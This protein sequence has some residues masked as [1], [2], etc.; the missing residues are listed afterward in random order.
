MFQ[1]YEVSTKPENGPKRLKKLLDSLKTA[2]FDGFLVPRSDAH[3]G[4]DVAEKDERLA[5]LTGFTGSAGMCVVTQSKTAIFV[6]SRY[7]LQAAT[8]VDTAHFAIKNIPADKPSDFITE[9]LNKGQTLAIDPWLHTKGEIEKIEEALTDAGINIAPTL[10][11]VDEIWENQPAPPANPITPHPIEFSGKSQ[12]D[13]RSEIAA[14]LRRNEVK[15]AILTLPDSIAWLLNIRGSDIKRT[16]VPLAFAALHDD[17]SV[18]LITD[19]AKLTQEVRDHLG[20]EITALEPIEFEAFLQSLKGRVAVDKDTAPLAVSSLLE[21]AE[22]I[23]QRD[24]C[25]LPKA[26]KNST[27]IDGARAAQKR[28]AAAMVEFLA[29]LDEEA[30]KGQLTEIDVAQKLEGFRRATNALKDISFETISGSGPNGAIVHYRVN[31]ETN[32]LISKGELL[33]VDSGGQYLDGTTDITRT[34]A[35]GA[36]PPDAKRVF[37]A[38]LKGMIAISML[39]FPEGLAGRDIDA[40]AHTALWQLGLDFHHGTGHGVGSYLGVHEGPAS[41]SKRSVE[42]LKPGMILSNEPG[43]YREGAFGIRIENLICVEA[44]MSIEGG[45]IDMLGFETLTYVPIDRNLIAVDHLTTAER[46]WINAYHAECA[47]RIKGLV[48]QNAITWLDKAT[49]PL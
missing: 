37:T 10:N 29:W 34:I 38:V 22:I 13:K 26:L 45:D 1:N 31:T 49:R 25:I 12:A 35:V 15:T 21:N 32:R 6:D 8:Q 23:W 19:S 47:D 44:P 9:T 33:L 28:D 7:T 39:R 20:A 16:P 18:T 30:P 40:F 42:P 36:P 27:E 4:E 46:D 43:Y 3:R 2:G 48:S 24:P 5:W 11:F 17:G 41:I 14:E